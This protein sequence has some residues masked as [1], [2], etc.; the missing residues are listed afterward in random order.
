MKL[1]PRILYVDDD[2]MNLELMAYWL[3]NDRGFDL[4][5]AIDGREAVNFMETQTFDLFLLDYCLPDITA[6]GLC[7][8]IRQKDPVVPIIVYSALGRDVDR[9][10]AL[11]AGANAYLTKPEDIHLIEPTI[12][13]LLAENKSPFTSTGIAH[14][15]SARTRPGTASIV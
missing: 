9:R 10:S 3:S 6:A 2:R 15:R 8:K 14:S 12:K 1:P 13:R 7:R 5:M 4:T 11:E